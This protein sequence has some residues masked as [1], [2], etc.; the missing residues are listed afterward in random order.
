[1]KNFVSEGLALDFTAPAGG[2]VAGVPLIIGALLVVPSTT[3]AEGERFSGWTEGVYEFDAATHATTQAWTEA[4][5]LYWDDVAKKFTIT[6][7][8]N[9]KRGVAAEAKASTAATGKVKLIQ[10]L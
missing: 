8:G 5:L 9:T 1:M 3:A 6:A 10:T 7:T 4:Q 2:V